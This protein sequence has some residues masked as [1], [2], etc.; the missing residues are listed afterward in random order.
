MTTGTSTDRGCHPEARFTHTVLINYTCHKPIKKKTVYV[1]A[2]NLR[3]NR[4]I[5]SKLRQSNKYRQVN[6]FFKRRVRTRS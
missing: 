3:F 2:D 5:K 4:Q 6:F 1:N